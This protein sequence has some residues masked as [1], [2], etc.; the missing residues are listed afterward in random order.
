MWCRN[1]VAFV[2]VSLLWGAV[3]L[4]GFAFGWVAPGGVGWAE[5]QAAEHPTDTGGS[6]A[7]GSASL[8][9]PRLALEG[10][11]PLPVPPP[12][13]E[14]IDRAIERGVA[15]LVAHQ[16]PD[17]SWGSPRRTK[18]LNIYAPVPGSHHAFQTGTTALALSAL[19]E[20]GIQTPEV[21]RA[22]E[23]GEDWIF[24]HLPAL[25]RAT[26]DAL[27]NN[28]GHAYAIQ[29]LVRMYPRKPRDSARQQE[30][31][32]LISQQI[33]LLQRYETVDGGWCYYDFEFGTQKP[34]GS[35]LSFVSATVLIALHEAQQLGVEVP[36]SLV[37]R[38]VASIHRQRKADFSY[39]YGEYLRW[40]PMHPVNR[41]GGS[42]GRSQVCNLALRLWDDQQV[43]DGVLSTWLDRLFARN[44]WLDLGR[45]RPIPH[46]SFFAV[47]GY[48]FYYGHYYAGRCIELLP[49]QERANY[50]HQLATILLRL[51]EADGSWW[52]YPLYDYHQA[53]GT[54][55]ALMSLVRCKAGR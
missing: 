43:T 42:L 37:D 55:F 29:T 25:R 20:T 11:K 54:G 26:P 10:P 13:P 31:L 12:E 30:I 17:G 22:V 1:W 53:Y 24:V 28:W 44:G 47:A 52:D 32:R 5:Q 14:E 46:E 33:E 6:L 38:A 35:S 41:P 8:E 16:N 49:P 48:F 4:L 39:L 21:R 34:G 7:A 3:G 40:R 50:Q 15:F 2:R 18:G 51:Q 9:P 45:K 19:I 27:Y 23:R 36:R